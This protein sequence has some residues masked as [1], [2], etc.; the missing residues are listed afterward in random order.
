VIFAARCHFLDGRDVAANIHR[1]HT[2]EVSM[3]KAKSPVPQG[4]HT[5]TPMLTFDDSARAI[6]WY[7]KAF[8]A[9]EISRSVGPDGKV[10]HAQIQ[11]GNSQLMLH[12]AMMGGKSANGFGGSPISLWIYVEDCDA[13]FKRA[14]SAGGKVADGPMG[15]MSDQFWGDRCGTLTDPEGYTWTIATRKEDLTQD[16]MQRRAAEWMEKFA[17][18]S[19]HA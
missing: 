15:Q 7:K 4:L 9:E 17:T 2:S 1:H 8:G 12:D 13:L 19:A 14:T 16:E 11:V 10:M 3:A 5:V 18:Q 6:D